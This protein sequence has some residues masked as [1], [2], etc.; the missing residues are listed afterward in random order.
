MILL[1]GLVGFKGDKETKDFRNWRDESL[2]LQKI[3]FNIVSK[4]YKNS[5]NVVQVLRMDKEAK[6][7]NSD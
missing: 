6:H 5:R 7:R 3:S 4:P 1:C 2:V